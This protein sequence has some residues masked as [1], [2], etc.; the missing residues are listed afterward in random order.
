MARWRDSNGCGAFLTHGVEIESGSSVVPSAPSTLTYTLKFDKIVVNLYFFP[1][2]CL[3]NIALVA[4]KLLMNK[5]ASNLNHIY[6]SPEFWTQ[7]VSHHAWL[8]LFMK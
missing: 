8:T 7:R 2:H 6:L 4:L 1:Q 5:L 3:T